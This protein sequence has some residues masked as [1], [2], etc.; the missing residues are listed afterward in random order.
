MGD[1]TKR[2]SRHEFEC[3]CGC[4]FDTV[5]IEL[6]AI[7]EEAADTLLEEDLEAVKAYILINSGSRCVNHNASVGGGSK[8]QHLFGRACDFR[9]RVKHV[10][11]TVTDIH[12]DKVADYLEMKF[13]GQYGIGRYKGRTHFDTRT[14]GPARWDSR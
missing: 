6:P 13:P 2:L 7:L 10:D 8:S 1:L 9:I 11:G 5:D 12:P 14:H 4:G 3:Q